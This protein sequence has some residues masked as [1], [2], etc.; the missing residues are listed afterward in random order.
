MQHKIKQN[1]KGESKT[2][3]NKR[4]KRKRIIKTILNNNHDRIR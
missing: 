3:K 1:L 2:N 4:E